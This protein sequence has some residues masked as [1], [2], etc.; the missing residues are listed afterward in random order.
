MRYLLLMVLATAL[1]FGG[2]SDESSGGED[3]GIDSS[4][5]T[6]TDTEPLLSYDFEAQAPW[7]ECPAED[8][9]SGVTIVTVFDQADHN[10]GG[11]QDLRNIQTAVDFPQSGEWSQVGLWLELTCP[12]S[13]LCDHWDRSGSV[14][15]VLNPDDPTED[16]E[17]LE[18]ARHITPYNMGMCQYID[19][20][21]LAS[22][23]RGTQTLTSF[24]DTWV[25]PGHS[26]GEGWRITVKFAFY[27]GDDAGA[28][29]VINIFGKK[30]VNV[31]SLDP[32][33]NVDSQIDPVTV[34]IPATATRVEA[35]VTTTGHGFGYSYNCAEFCQMRQDVIVDG[36]IHS[37]NPWRA[38]CDQNPVSPQ[39]GTWEHNRNG[40]CPGAVSV[41]NIVDI[42]DAVT[43]GSNAEIDFD[44]L[45]SDGAE[46]ENT[47]TNEG[48]PY[49]IIALKLYIYE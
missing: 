11:E 31:G 6:D 14:Q 49:E 25:G 9:P 15:L 23:L 44:I 32:S 26:D 10:F 7:F 16:W 28:D 40:W 33:D 18:L 21:P 12:E 3:G 48:S 17:Y 5:D 41:G 30:N 27:S 29:Q 34:S 35:H 42:T 43:P 8:L 13:G 1:V 24:I 4:T 47:S 39:A 2:C 22:L 37:V 36:V 38:D 20:T 19:V 45:A 46:Y